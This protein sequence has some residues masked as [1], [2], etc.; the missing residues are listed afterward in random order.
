MRKHLSPAMIIALVALFFA[1]TGGAAAAG[2]FIITS[3]NQIKPSVLT[4]IHGQ[5]GPKGDAGPA[6]PMGPTGQQGAAGAPGAQGAQG[7][8]GDNG[9]TGATGATGPQ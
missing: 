1:L 4:K 7:A 6:G 8:K 2:H 5:T 9:D 3:T